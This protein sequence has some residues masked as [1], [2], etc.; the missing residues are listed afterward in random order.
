MEALLPSLSSSL[1][2]TLPPSNNTLFRT[3]SITS[4]VNLVSQKRCAI[5]TGNRRSV[6]RITAMNDVSAVTSPAEVEVTWQIV[7]GVIAGVTPFVVAGIEFS[8]R[9]M[10]HKRCEVCGGSGLVLRDKYYFRCPGC[11]STK[12]LGCWAYAL[13]VQFD[14]MTWQLHP[15]QSSFFRG[16]LAVGLIWEM[17]LIWYVNQ[18]SDGLSA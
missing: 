18:E 14:H 17:N 1:P 8:K 12:A 6:A 16:M 11:D 9:I 7:V 10:A 5:F 3:K 13:V 2:L 15:V 4:T